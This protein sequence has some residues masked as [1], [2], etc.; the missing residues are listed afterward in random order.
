MLLTI[1]LFFIYSCN[2]KHPSKSEHQK[3]FQLKCGDES[4]I[5][6]VD[7]RRPRPVTLYKKSVE[8]P[9][10]APVRTSSKTSENEDKDKENDIS[11]EEAAI[12]S[13]KNR[14]MLK[15]LWCDKRNLPH[16]R[17]KRQNERCLTSGKRKKAVQEGVGHVRL[18]AVAFGSS[19]AHSKEIVAKSQKRL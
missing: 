3:R 5:V 17:S 10:K 13:L 4:F 9:K 8:P 6:D 7:S 18:L 12:E 11:K 15:S 14:W 19:A 1:V 16:Y 2:R